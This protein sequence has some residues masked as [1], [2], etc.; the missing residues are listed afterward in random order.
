MIDNSD[1]KYADSGGKDPRGKFISFASV[2]YLNL[3]AC[4][5]TEYLLSNH[6]HDEDIESSYTLADRMW[7]FEYVGLYAQ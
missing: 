4:V 6:S 2:L 5:E 3:F 7:S 1:F